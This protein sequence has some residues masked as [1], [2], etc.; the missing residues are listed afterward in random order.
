LSAELL[1]R[2]PLGERA[3]A[4]ADFPVSVGGPGNTITLAG[5]P[6]EP[7]AWIALHDGQ[8]FLQ[9][10]AAG[11]RLLCNG[12]PLTRSTWLRDGDVV[13][14][15]TGR[16]RLRLLGDHRVIE[17]EDG[18]AGNLT[19]PPVPD[20]AEVVIGGGNDADE[21]IEAVAFRRPAET[22]RQRRSPRAMAASLLAV[23]LLVPVLW[24]LW[25]GRSVEV[26]TQPAAD[27]VRLHGGF[28]ALRTGTRHFLR[29]GNYELVAERR[30]YEPLRRPVKVSDARGQRFEFKL[31]KLPGRLRVETPVTAEVAIDGKPAGRAPG[32]F[33]LHPGRHA[34]VVTAERYLPFQ[35]DVA[36]AGEDRQ[37]V[38]QAQLVPAW[39]T[40]TVLSEPAGAEVRVGGKARGT[41]P[42]KLD[43]AA[44][45]HR[46]AI[47]HAGF[48][49]W[50]SDVQI[51][52]NQ[53]QTLGPVRLG[54]P[55]ARLFVRS[56]PAGANLSVG[57]AYRGRTPADIDV[58]PETPLPM[59]LAKDGY[60]SATTSVTLAPGER[61][62]LDLTLTPI[63]GELTVQASPADAEV[64]ADGRTLGR[65][66]QTYR[67]PAATHQIEVR[68][69]GFR[70]Y[71]TS[72]T[73]RPGLPQVIDVRLDEARGAAVTEVAA[74]PSV[75]PASGPT[76]SSPAAA[77]QGPPAAVIRTKSGQ[78]LKLVPAGTFTMGSPRR[79]SGR[80]ANESQRPV[81]LRRR[82]YLATREVTNA[83][84][85]LFR[86]DHRS[87]YVGQSTLERD[88]Q[89][90]VAVSWQDAAAYCNWLSKQEGLP[91]AYES[92]GGGLVPVVPATTGY[93]LPTEAEW[94]WAA[95]ANRDGSLRK[96]PWGDALPVPAG[97]G[98]FGDRSAQPLLQQVIDGV[99]DG[100]PVTA[101][102]GAFAPNALGFY[103]LG[104]NVA[105][106]TGD[107]YTVQPPASALAVDPFAAGEGK[108]H[109]IRGSSWRH[110]T[111]TELRLAFRDYGDG[112]RDDVGLRIARYA[113]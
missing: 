96:Y 68:A 41:T 40:L 28:P 11:V 109:V 85:R 99:D 51:V 70:S 2:D 89:P 50:V 87:G 106:W 17:V 55:D 3:L 30:G 19:L 83:E 105:E 71:R 43:L 77:A 26:I 61:R 56:N 37:Q 64:V 8:L 86:P 48:K 107:L 21:R 67:L 65:V 9:P 100:N 88:K 44:G 12:V 49:E 90:V 66:G 39:A 23:A 103:D 102:V 101:P 94:E 80:R 46:V 27:V 10:E 74:A 73:P 20:G 59:V 1:I 112:G 93:R 63:L 79:E 4:A 33:K 16:L 76:P 98:N 14:A 58:R 72:V 42:A 45:S 60:E 24:F 111:V 52:A 53:P 32:E 95:R 7:R 104:G 35:S 69:P 36:I 97:A 5:L 38:L 62:T 81:E 113:E 29:P 75:A 22:T 13:D 91:A 54:L 82:F 34:V 47:L 78:E 57:G 25:T 15:G 92:K 6:A 18:S 31:Q 84:F 108:L 110:A